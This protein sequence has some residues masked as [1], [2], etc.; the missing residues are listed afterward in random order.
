MSLVERL[1]QEHKQRLARMSRPPV[2]EVVPPSPIVDDTMLQD[3]WR[4]LE[5]NVAKEYLSTVTRIQL[6]VAKEFN[7]SRHDMISARRTA[8][9]N[10][11][12]Q[13][14]MYLSKN[15]TLKSLPDLGRR[16]GGRDHTT[17]L[18][19]VRKVAN[20]V[21]IDTAYAERVERLKAQFIQEEGQCD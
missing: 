17:V 16:F 20:R 14:A 9:L 1:H 13:I 15:I 11:P 8:N 18:H 19:A 4:L 7:V 2:R 21:A 6:T 3:A 10:E 12:R 5:K